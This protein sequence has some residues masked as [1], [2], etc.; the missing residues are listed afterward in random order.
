MSL[1]PDSARFLRISQPRPPAPLK[2]HSQHSEPRAMYF[3]HTNITLGRV[4]FTRQASWSHWFCIQDFGV[5]KHA[6]GHP[7]RIR[8]GARLLQHIVKVFPVCSESVHSPA[9]QFHFSINHFGVEKG[10]AAPSTTA[11]YPGVLRCC[12]GSTC[13]LLGEYDPGKE[14]GNNAFGT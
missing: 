2:C 3:P 11:I 5:S 10:F 4:S 1:K 12:F 7:V 13:L 6:V 9:L 14:T 8:K